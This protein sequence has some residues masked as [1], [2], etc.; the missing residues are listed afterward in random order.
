MSTATERTN[1]IPLPHRPEPTNQPAGSGTLAP[2]GR[3]VYTVKEVAY[4]LSLSLGS[5]YALIR[6][7]DIPAR[8]M[9][10]RWVVPRRRF[11]E[12]LNNLPT[13]SVDDLDRELGA[14]ER[15]ATRQRRNGA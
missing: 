12:W 1:V 15:A 9:G 7:G 5:T 8:K 2:V 13:A 14:L 3:A 11:E 6:S 10:G 4:Q